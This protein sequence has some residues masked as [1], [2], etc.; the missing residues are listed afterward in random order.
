MVD[1][2][3]SCDCEIVAQKLAYMHA[4]LRHAIH[5]TAIGSDQ[6]VGMNIFDEVLETIE[7]MVPWLSEE[8]E[9]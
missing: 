4:R 3:E 7:S 1:L 8:Q 2:G 6:G 9:Q 5:I